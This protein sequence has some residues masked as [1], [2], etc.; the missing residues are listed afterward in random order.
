[1]MKLLLCAMS[2]LLPLTAYA[3]TTIELN[4]YLGGQQG[5]L[6]GNPALIFKFGNGS[7]KNI[8]SII[9]TEKYLRYSKNRLENI[10]LSE[11]SFYFDCEWKGKYY[12]LSKRYRTYAEVI[13][14]EPDANF[15]MSMHI[16][17]KL[18]SITGERASI[19]SG[20]ISLRRM[21]GS[22]PVF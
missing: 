13:I 9:T 1:M 12:F 21:E 3:T 4:T 22:E 2:F 20:D 5:K 6:A 17:A 18:V 16:E 19:V 7:D 15:P 14:K 11:S 8:C 10:N